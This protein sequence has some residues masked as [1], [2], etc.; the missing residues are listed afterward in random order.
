MLSLGPQE[1]CRPGWSYILRT[2]G[3]LTFFLLLGWVPP[4]HSSRHEAAEAKSHDGIP[5]GEIPQDY[6]SVDYSNTSSESG[7]IH[8]GTGETANYRPW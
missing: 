8:G 2:A 7:A 6:D 5:V 4:G 3:M 1:V